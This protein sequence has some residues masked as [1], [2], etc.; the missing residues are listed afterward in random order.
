[1]LSVIVPVY[2]VKKYLQKCLDSLFNQTL[3]DIEFIIVDD[4]STDGSSTFLD[5]YCIAFSIALTQYEIKHIIQ[6]TKIIFL[7][8]EELI[9]FVFILRTD[10]NKLTN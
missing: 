3:K 8:A 2:N 10:F 1:M 6:K 7:T 9:I 4:G 5:S